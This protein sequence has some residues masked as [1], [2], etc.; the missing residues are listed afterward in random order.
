MKNQVK[1]CEQ[2]EAKG[3]E[4]RGRQVGGWMVIIFWPLVFG[5]R[6]LRGDEEGSLCRQAGLGGDSSLG[7]SW[8]S[9]VVDVG[10]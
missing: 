9:W 5:Q 1:T 10:V 6:A 7:A 3:M 4:I 2:F 8:D